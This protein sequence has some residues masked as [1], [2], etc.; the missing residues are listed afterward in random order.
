MAVALGAEW[1]EKH[2]TFDRSAAGFDH[3]NSLDTLQL[4]QYVADI[5]SATA[6]LQR[7][8]VKVGEKEA[9]TRSRARRALH[10]A[11]DLAPGHII[12]EADVNIVRP[13]GPLAPGDLPLILG[14][15]LA[16]PI[17]QNEPFALGHLIG[18]V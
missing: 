2:Y 13:E 3:A 4:V 6:A 18:A 8:A 12:T 9:F 5:R 1:F 11:R 7:P 10:A 17:A 16:Q 14:Q 15:K